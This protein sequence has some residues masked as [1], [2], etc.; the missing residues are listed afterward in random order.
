MTHYVIGLIDVTDPDGMRSYGPR[1][2]STIARYGGRMVFAGPVVDVLEGSIE[3]TAGAVI[4]FEDEPAATRWFGSPEYAELRRL[5][6]SR[7]TAHHLLVRADAP[8]PART[9]E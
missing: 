5:R 6:E 1:V 9:E 4:E 8:Q 3:A 2:G 7:A